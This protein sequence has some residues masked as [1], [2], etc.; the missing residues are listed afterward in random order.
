MLLKPSPTSM[1]AADEQSVRAG[2]TE[3]NSP[4]K[5]LSCVCAHRPKCL[6]HSLPVPLLSAQERMHALCCSASEV[7]AQHTVRHPSA[8]MQRAMQWKE[9]WPHAE[10]GCICSLS[11]VPSSWSTAGPLLGFGRHCPLTGTREQPSRLHAPSQGS[12]TP[13]AAQGHRQ[14][15]L[16]FSPCQSEQEAAVPG[17]PRSCLLAVTLNLNTE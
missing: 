2:T 14:L 15:L 12:P 11:A 3:Q 13:P 8:P 17:R 4:C 5:A 7:G 1:E 10:L 9:V 6:Q 16:Q